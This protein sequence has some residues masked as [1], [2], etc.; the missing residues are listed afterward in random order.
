MLLKRN[1]VRIKKLIVV[2]SNIYKDISLSIKQNYVNLGK[3]ST[4]S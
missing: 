4:E 3:F 2:S 1:N